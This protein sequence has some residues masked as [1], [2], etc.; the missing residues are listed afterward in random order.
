LQKILAI[1]ESLLELVIANCT[2][3][4]LHG[5]EAIGK[6]QYAWEGSPIRCLALWAPSR[7]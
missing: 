2:T 6:P 1:F 3:R 7:W 4:G 5:T